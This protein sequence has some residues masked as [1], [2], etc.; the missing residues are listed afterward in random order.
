MTP[1]DVRAFEKTMTG[2]DKRVDV[3]IYDGAGHAFED[4]TNVQG[5][6]PEAAAD[7]WP[8]SVAFLNKSLK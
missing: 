4:S 2:L 1:D 6:R 7:A 5:Y 8:R 3:K